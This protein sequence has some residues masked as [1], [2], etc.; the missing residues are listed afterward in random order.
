LIQNGLLTFVLFCKVICAGYQFQ[1]C[2][3]PIITYQFH[4]DLLKLISALF[5]PS[6][7]VPFPYDYLVGLDIQMSISS[8]GNPF[9]AVY[10]MGEH[11]LKGWWY[12]YITAVLIKTPILLSLLIAI[13]GFSLL[14][15][16]KQGM[17]LTT[18]LCLWIP[19]AGYFLYFSLMTHIQVGYRYLLP[20]YPLAIIASVYTF[21]LPFFTQRRKTVFLSAIILVY[22]TTTL[23]SYPNYLS[24]FNLLI[25]GPKNGHKFLINSN[26]DWGQDLPALKRYMEDKRIDK[27]KLGYFGR[28]NPRLYGIDYEP[29]V[30]P[31]G[32]GR[33]APIFLWE[34]LIIS[35]MNRATDSFQ[36]TGIITKCSKI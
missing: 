27:I 5:H 25:G 13:S 8:G 20:I 17:D 15:K 23:F 3:Q 26:L 33:Y 6:F 36:S 35:S 28:V 4:S 1:Q 11:S 10:L 22:T 29:A 9:Y 18:T 21:K 2:Y 12:A 30:H 31:F 24:Y 14:T 34:G 7:P 16:A 32:P 19:I